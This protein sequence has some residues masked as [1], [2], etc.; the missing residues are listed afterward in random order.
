MTFVV[1][2]TK[3]EDATTVVRLRADTAVAKARELARM[4]WK[5]FIERPG[6]ARNYPGDF[7][8]LLAD[9]RDDSALPLRQTESNLDV[10]L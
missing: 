3:G 8:N 5:V 10:A 6:G 2:E 7:D 9:S 4:G 1:C